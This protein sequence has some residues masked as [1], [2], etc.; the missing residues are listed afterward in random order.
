LA[1]GSNFSTL[2]GA[3]K[4]GKSIWNYSGDISLL[5]LIK[6]IISIMCK[7]FL[8]GNSNSNILLPKY[9]FKIQ[10]I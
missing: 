2:A 4:V 7:I 8:Y 1:C 10:N 5:A 6:N 9:I 3:G